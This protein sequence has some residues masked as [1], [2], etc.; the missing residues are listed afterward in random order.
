MFNDQALASILPTCTAHR[1]SVP[2]LTQMPGRMPRE[3]DSFLQ[4]HRVA[5][6]HRLVE[7]R[8]G[9]QE[10]L[11]ADRDRERSSLY[12]SALLHLS[13]AASRYSIRDVQVGDDEPSDAEPP[14]STMDAADEQYWDLHAQASRQSEIRAGF[15]ICCCPSVLHMFW[16]RAYVLARATASSRETC[17]NKST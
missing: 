2:R 6:L 5:E 10:P 7:A 8:R 11:D 15:R 14:S 9:R 12:R 13:G 1:A 4:L 17:A 3:E 16:M